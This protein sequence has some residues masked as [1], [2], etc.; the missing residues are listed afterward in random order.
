[1][2]ERKGWLF[3]Q[4]KRPEEA[5]ITQVF[6]DS[7]TFDYGPHLNQTDLVFV[8]GAHSYDYIRKDTEH[9][10][11]LLRHGHGVV[12]WHDYCTWWPGV[13]QYLEELHRTQALGPI[14]NI[15]G[16]TVIAIR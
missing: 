9:A 3:H 8:D 5:K 12:A 10:V 1:M 15:A 14:R 7:A 2:Q 16:T 6:G 11:R 4:G 13:I